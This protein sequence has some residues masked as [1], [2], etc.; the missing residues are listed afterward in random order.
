MTM[1]NQPLIPVPLSGERLAKRVAALRACSRRQAEQ[2]IEGGWVRVNG[3]MVEEPQHRVFDELIEIDPNARLVADSARTLL[4]NKPAGCESGE[5]SLALLGAASHC[6]NDPAGIRP[7]KRH[8]VGL[9]SWVGLET[10]AS[11]LLVFTQDWRVAR[12]LSEDA[13]LLEHEYSVEVAGQVSS[14]TLERLKQGLGSKTQPLPR[15]KVSISSSNQTSARLRFAVKGACIGLLAQLCETVGL[16][17]LSMKR[18]RIG[19]VVLAQ[20][21][22]GQW[23]YLQTHERF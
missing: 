1:H 15:V 4:L 17:I 3:V 2:F 6:S 21:P 23:R 16:K 11:G 13:A 10:G 12:K 7:L 14:D 18:I 20:L 22:P 9:R 8:F 5:S 19:R